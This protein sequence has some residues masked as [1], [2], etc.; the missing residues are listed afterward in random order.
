MVSR[1][2]PLPG[3]GGRGSSGEPGRPGNLIGST[4]EPFGHSVE[5]E[6]EAGKRTQETHSGLSV[7]FFSPL[8]PFPLPLSYPG[9]DL[10]WE[11]AGM[12]STGVA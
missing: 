7:L 2:A 10:T 1:E 6:C 3:C 12:T 11:D 4:P 8:S 9:L 5:L